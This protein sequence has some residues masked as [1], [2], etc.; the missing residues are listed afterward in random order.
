MARLG[1]REKDLGT[2]VTTLRRPS[3]RPSSTIN[4]Q[5]PDALSLQEVGSPAALDDLVE[6]LDGGWHRRVSQHPDQRHIRVAWLTPHDIT[7]HKDNDTPKAATTQLLLGPPGSENSV[8][9]DPEVRKNE[10]SSDH[11]PVVATFAHV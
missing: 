7:D 2:P 10:P 5:A 6:L 9:E 8:T 3:T 1:A 11:A 4:A